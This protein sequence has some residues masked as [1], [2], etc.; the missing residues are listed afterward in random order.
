MGQSGPD[1]LGSGENSPTSST[2][3]WAQGARKFDLMSGYVMCAERAAGFGLAWSG[4]SSSVAWRRADRGTR[5]VTW[6]RFAAVPEARRVRGRLEVGARG[7]P[8]APAGPRP[9]ADIPCSPTLKVGLGWGLSRVPEGPLQIQNS[10]ELCFLPGLWASI[11]L[12][13]SHIAQPL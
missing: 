12:R 10:S 3:G 8:S 1:A 4:S 6:N 7:R 11:R 9:P 2:P 13:W 5:A